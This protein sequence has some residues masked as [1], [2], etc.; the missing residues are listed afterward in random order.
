MLLHYMGGE[1]YDTVS[2]RL[3]PV[4]SQT[5]SYEEIVQLLE[6]H[7]NPRPL[8]IL[9]NFR[10]KCRKQGDERVD[11]SIDDYLI[12]LRKLA[13]TCNFGDYLPTALRNQFVFGLRDRAIQAR[14]LEV[15]DLTLERARELAISMELSAKGG[16]EIHSRVKAELNL[17][18]HPVSKSAKA[19]TVGKSSYSA[20]SDSKKGA[21]Y[22]CGSVGHFTNKCVHVKTV[23]NFCH[24]VGHLQKV[25]QKNARNQGT[26]DTHS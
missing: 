18:E 24:L 2:D 3:A 22:R 14:L 21:C 4:K 1:T 11:E 9:E 12:T 13:I 17:V 26:S 6:N 25:C 15:H 20:P 7:F 16:Q 8:E 19:K 5:K 23:C 10:F